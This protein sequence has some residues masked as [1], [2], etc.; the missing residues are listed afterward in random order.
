MELTAALNDAYATLRQPFRRAEYLLALKG[1]PSASEHKE[2]APAFLEEML[3]TWERVTTDE[4]IERVESEGGDARAKLQRTFALTSASDRLLAIEARSVA[5]YPGGWADYARSQ[6]E[7]VAAAAAA[8]VAP[9]KPKREKPKRAAKRAPSA[10]ELVEG[11]VERAEARVA[12]LEQKLA[13]D[14]GDAELLSAH[15][16]AR[17]DLEALL[18]R[19]ESLFAETTDR[20]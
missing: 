10:L 3:D 16:A 18:E 7:E 15:K 1:G 14:W 19:W 8:A 9:S 13:A 12:E 17:L 5:S 2:M 11:E 20:I 4:V 6:E